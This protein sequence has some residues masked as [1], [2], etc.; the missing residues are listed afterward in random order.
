MTKPTARGSMPTI[1]GPA[2]PA[3]LEDA[4]SLH[5]TLI[6]RISCALELGGLNTHVAIELIVEQL[7]QR[8]GLSARAR[9]ELHELMMEVVAFDP[10][11]RAL[12]ARLQPHPYRVEPIAAEVAEKG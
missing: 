2:Q 9:A 1:P 12:V 11:L 4:V 6:D 7:V 3:A 8:S 5:R 10:H